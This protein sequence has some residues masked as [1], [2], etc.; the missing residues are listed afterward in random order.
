[1]DVQ[2]AAFLASCILSAAK[3][4][5]DRDSKD[6]RFEPCA[7]AD[8]TCLSSHECANA[9]PRELAFGLLIKALHLGNESLEG[10]C[11]FLFTVAPKLHFNRLAIG[12]EVKCGFESVRQIGERHVFIH[13][14]MF[15]Q[16]ILQVP[17]IDSHAFCAATPRC[18]CSFGQRFGLIRNH[19]VRIDYELCPQTVASRAGAEMAIERKMSGL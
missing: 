9:I 15:G 10:L 4:G 7:A 17:I 19:Q 13:L 14:E 12:A 16:R 2:F 5:S 1:M 18:D 8:I 3:A 6:F 11:Y